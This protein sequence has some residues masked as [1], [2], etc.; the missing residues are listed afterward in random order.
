MLLALIIP[1]ETAAALC[2]S[3]LYPFSGARDV[4]TG[5][6]TEIPGYSI[7]MIP[8]GDGSTVTMHIFLCIARTG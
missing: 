8:G 5:E 6:Q 7:F 1:S 3:R 2:S 4:P